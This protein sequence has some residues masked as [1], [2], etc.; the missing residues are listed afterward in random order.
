MYSYDAA[1][2]KININMAKI[3]R[4]KQNHK[5]STMKI[6][7]YDESIVCIDFENELFF[8]TMNDVEEEIERSYSMREKLRQEKRLREEN[9]TLQ[10]LWD[11]YQVMLKLLS[12]ADKKNEKR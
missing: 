10:R 11:E 5:S 9:E 1:S 4:R 7:N 12:D 3:I 8:L 6:D 2:N